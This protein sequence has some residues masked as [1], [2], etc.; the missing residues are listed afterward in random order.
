MR[1]DRKLEHA[2]RIHARGGIAR[3]PAP[4]VCPSR[5]VHAGAVRGLLAIDRKADADTPAVG[6]AR[7]LAPAL[8]PA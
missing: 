1:T 7:A 5:I 2:V 3:A 6:L 8:R 4:W